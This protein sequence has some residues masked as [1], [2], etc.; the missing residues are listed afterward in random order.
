MDRAQFEESLDVET[1]YIER[2]HVDKNLVDVVRL[3]ELGSRSAIIHSIPATPEQMQILRLNL[4]N[5]AQLEIYSALA[6]D[7]RQYDQF[8]FTEYL[9][10][11]KIYGDFKI[12]GFSPTPEELRK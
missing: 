12:I 1:F 4:G 7:Q 9:P 6:I 2:I 8:L 5:L 10:K 11:S 3:R